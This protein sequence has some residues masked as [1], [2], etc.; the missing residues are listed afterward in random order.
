MNPKFA[1]LEDLY[2]RNYTTYMRMYVRRAEGPQAAEDIIHDAFE[3]AMRYIDNYNEEQEIDKWFHP[4]LRNSFRDYMRAERGQP[5]EEV[6]EFDHEGAR[7]DG[8]IRKTWQEVKELIE[9][10]PEKHKE[11]LTLHFVNEYSVT[12]IS[13]FTDNTLSNTSQVV[14]RFRVRV[15]EIYGKM[16]H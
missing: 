4:I 7:C 15:K 5:T 13:R 2:T 9:G 1:I 6:D 8:F 16:I 12:D 11:I 10:Y 3:R 14:N